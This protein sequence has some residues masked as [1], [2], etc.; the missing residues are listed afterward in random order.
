[1]RVILLP[2]IVT[3]CALVAFTTAQF[4]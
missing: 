4:L 1:L 3:F 2:L